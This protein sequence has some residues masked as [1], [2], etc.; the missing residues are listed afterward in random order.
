[1]PPR[2]TTVW[3]HLLNAGLSFLDYLDA[4]EAERLA[5]EA[6]EAETR[7]EPGDTASRPYAKHKTPWWRVLGLRGIP[8]ALAD[9]ERAYRRRVA[10]CHPDR[11]GSEAAFRAL[12]SALEEARV[13]FRRI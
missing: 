11:G 13:F 8:A 1:M 12:R 3:R 5:E 4:R 6:E 9:A 7:S 10:E 2:D